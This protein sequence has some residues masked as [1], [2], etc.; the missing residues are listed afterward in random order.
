M[1][2]INLK[3]ADVIETMA[4]ERGLTVSEIKG[5][6]SFAG[7]DVNDLKLS[8]YVDGGDYDE[9]IEAYDEL[10]IEKDIAK[11]LDHYS[12][13][14]DGFK[15][16]KMLY[17]RLATYFLD[18]AL[19]FV[20]TIDGVSVD[21]EFEKRDSKMSTNVHTGVNILETENDFDPDIFFEVYEELREKRYESERISAHT[22][23]MLRRTV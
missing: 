3:F 4:K 5:K 18:G 2:T 20:D 23:E 11:I 6:L 9:T 8:F 12:R 1:N 14:K 7:N 19:Y 13:S 10:Y 17:K 21:V 22:Y 15:V 16:S